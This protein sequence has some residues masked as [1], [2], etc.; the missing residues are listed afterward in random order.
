M[1]VYIFF[2]KAILFPKIALLESTSRETLLVIQEARVTCVCSRRRKTLKLHF[3]KPEQAFEENWPE[4][5]VEYLEES[6][7][8]S[9]LSSRQLP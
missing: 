5:R 4:M 9:M 8:K 2:S 1:F 7:K 3:K 6:K